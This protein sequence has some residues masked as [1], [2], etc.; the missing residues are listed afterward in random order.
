MLFRGFGRI[1]NLY[2]S[3]DNFYNFNT[4]ESIEGSAIV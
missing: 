2:F 1:D 3:L 4:C